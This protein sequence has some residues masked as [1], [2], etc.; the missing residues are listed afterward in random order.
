MNAAPDQLEARKDAARAWFESLQL[1]II[2]AFEALEDEAPGPFATG[3]DAPGRFVLTSWSRTDHS[4][5]TLE[6]AAR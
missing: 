5:A 4:G 1:R 6:S 2:A 3:S